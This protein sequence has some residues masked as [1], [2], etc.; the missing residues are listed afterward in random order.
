[1]LR[2]GI[3]GCGVIAAR[4]YIP[5]FQ[6]L[7]QR[8]T[9]VGLCDLNENI[10]HEVAGK[11]GIRTAYSDFSRMLA[12][13]RPDVV[14]VCTPPA[15]HTKLVIGALENKAHVLV[16]KPMALTPLDCRQMVDAAHRHGRRLGVMHNQIFNPAFERA[17][18]MVAAGKI[19]KFLGMRIFLMTPADDMT[20]NPSHWAHRLPGGVVGETGPHAVY[21]SLALLDKV[22]DVQ[23]CMKKLLPE[24]PWSAAEDVRFD[25]V[26]S[27]GISSVALMYGSDQAAAEIEIIG[28]EGMLKMDLQ[29]RILVKHNRAVGPELLS[30]NAVIRSVVGTIY[31]T[32][33]GLAKNGIQHAWSKTLD[34]HY[35][36]IKRFLDHVTNGAEYRATGEKAAEVTEVL[37]DVIQKLQELQGGMAGRVRP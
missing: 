3:V 36:G 27:N 26:A 18:D 5:I 9:I 34:G 14:V 11:F 20:T 33:V 35:V 12:D 17:C 25:L 2:V 10:L 19:G 23:V 21:L 16:E 8:V 7:K 4:K 15:T 22:T 1:M 30:A 31:Q 37:E 13:A 29:S 24:Y 6:R 32:S 28:T